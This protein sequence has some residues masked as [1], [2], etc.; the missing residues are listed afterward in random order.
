MIADAD[1][2]HITDQDG[3]AILR[4]DDRALDVFDV[5]VKTGA[6]QD[7]PFITTTQNAATRTVVVGGKGIGQLIERDAITSHQDRVGIDLNFL[8]GATKAGDIGDTRYP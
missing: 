1:L 4:T 5:P 3:P 2:R 8:D 6:A 7:Q